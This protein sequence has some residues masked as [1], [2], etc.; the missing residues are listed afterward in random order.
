[1]RLF[2]YFVEPASY[3]L[4]LI[5]NIYNK[6]Q[7]DYCFINSHSLAQSD[8]TS[9]QPFLDRLSFFSKLK[10]LISVYKN[11]DL[12]IVNGYNNYPFFITFILHLFSIK[13][14]YISIDSDTQF[15]IPGNLL[16]RLIKWVYL[17]IIFRNK[18]ILG[19]AGGT[20]THKDLFRNYGMQESRIFFMPMVVDNS[21]FYL[22]KK[23]F[24]DLFTFLYVGRLVGH[25]N[26]EGV[27]KQFRANF[28]DKKAILKIVGSGK[29]ERYLRDKYASDHVLFLGE[30]F[31]D[32]LVF[33]F[34]NASC[35]VIA[36]TFEPWGLVVNEALSA[37]LPVIAYKEVGATYDLIKGRSTGVI[38]A[39][40]NEFGNMMLTLYNDPDLLMRFSKN[41]SDV[42]RNYWNYELYAECL[43]EVIKKVEKSA[44][45]I[46]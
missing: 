17:S 11:Y 8:L 46:S 12:I 25:K 37:S 6:N 1:M 13:K 26:V 27:I 34:R 44:R 28:P 19:F 21:R 42:M 36:S 5:K 7:I 30:L 33:E 9:N 22:E 24:P 20:H 38:A 3:T 10:F 41:A 40:M 4:D 32:D 15:R 39:D 29:E 23:S 2:C 14:K 43:M 45:C 35:F 16:K 31:N 18:Y